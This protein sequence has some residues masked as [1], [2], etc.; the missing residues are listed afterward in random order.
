MSNIEELRIRRKKEN[1]VLNVII[2]I[3]CLIS[4]IFFGNDFE[5]VLNN[6]YFIINSKES[7]E[8][9]IKNKERYVMMDLQNSNLEMYSLKGVKTKEQLNLYTVT[10]DDKKLMI[11]L[12]NNTALTSK[13]YLNIEALDGQKISIEKLLD[14]GEY[15]NKILSNENFTLNRNIDLIKMY[16]FVSLI[17]LSIILI[18]FDIIYYKNP[19]KTIKYKKYMK[20]LYIW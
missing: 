20:K 15:Y 6:D 1:I 7:L 10:Y 2:I 4:L 18:I 17:I 14:N 16:V 3:I 8:E 19:K 11:F 9:A 13:V 5:K 12:R